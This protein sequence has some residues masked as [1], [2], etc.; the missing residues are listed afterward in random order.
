MDVTWTIDD[1]RLI[2]GVGK[3]DLHFL[4]IDVAGNLC[5]KIDDQQIT[6]TEIISQVGTKIR[7]RGFPRVPSFTL[8]IP[9]L[10]SSQI[11]KVSK[12]FNSDMIEQGYQGR[13][14]AVYPL[15]VNPI[16]SVIK[17]ILSTNPEY[18]LE[19]GTK[20][21]LFIA[22]KELQNDKSRIIIC[23]GV[24]DAEYIE[25]VRQAIEED[26]QIWVSVESVKEAKITLERLPHEKMQLALR[27]KPYVSIVSHW[28]ASSGRHSK[29][30]LAIHDLIQIIELLKKEKVEHV[31]V[32][33]HAHPGSQVLGNIYAFAEHIAHIYIGLRDEGFFN[34][35]VINVGG[36]LPINY[37]GHLIPGTIKADVRAI[38]KALLKVLGTDYPH[39]DIM[40]ESGRVLTA[41]YSLLVIRAFDLR[42]IFPKWDSK[43]IEESYEYAQVIKETKKIQDPLLVLH[44]WHQWLRHATDQ[45]ELSQILVYEQLT[46]LVKRELRQHF[47]QLDNYEA[48]LDDPLAK[49][50]LRPEFI[51]QGN[52][53]V[54][55]GAC[56]HVL[57]GQYF[58]ILPIKGLHHQPTTLVRLVDITCDSDGEISNYHPPLSERRLYTKD[59]F[60]LTTTIKQSWEGFPVGDMKSI[61]DDYLVITLVGAYQDVIELDHNLIGD[62]PDVQLNLTPSREWKIKWLGSAQSIQELVDEVGFSLP[63]LDDPYID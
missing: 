50:L 42:S 21:E 32:A 26:Y 44:A 28:G 47:V 58:P 59:G 45:I 8:R 5:I 63:H 13:F 3:E 22:L 33:I 9:Q 10:I 35:S 49:D 40:S 57:V 18:G 6:I 25:I 16:K 17:Q 1:S 53:S 60:P 46:G 4:D 20:S 41:L 2:Y 27:I 23:N 55:N 37:D 12:I 54:F 14:R 43:A 29:F 52:F 56:D 31:V 24:K 36:G 30:G 34:L 61:D 39:P 38:I 7:E 15:K 51:I 11:D 48:F 19:V 62:L